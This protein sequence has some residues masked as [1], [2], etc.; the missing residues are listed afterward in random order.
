MKN[1]EHNV[2]VGA[3]ECHCYYF[4]ACCVANHVG[5]CSYCRH[6][7]VAGAHAAGAHAAAFLLA[8]RAALELQLFNGPHCATHSA[9]CAKQKTNIAEPWTGHASAAAH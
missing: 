2:F 4:A 9:K 6:T 7:A 8:H 3:A 5:N 1:V